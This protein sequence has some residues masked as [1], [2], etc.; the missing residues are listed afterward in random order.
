MQ[1]STLVGVSMALAAAVAAGA[2]VWS[3]LPA[4]RTVQLHISGLPD[5][6]STTVRFGLHEAEAIAPGVYE[7]TVRT[8]ARMLQVTGGLGEPCE[9]CCFSLSQDVPVA[10]NSEAITLS[11]TVPECPT[12]DY[13]TVRVA[14]GAVRIDGVAAESRRAVV[15]GAPIAA[16]LWDGDGGCGEP[17]VGCVAW[18]EVI[19]FANRLSIAEGLTPAYYHDVAHHFPYDHRGGTVHWS[20]AADGWR[21]PTE[22]E[23]VLSIGTS[24]AWEWIWGTFAEPY[25]GVTTTQEEDGPRTVRGPGRTARI[26]P[27]A[28]LGFRLVRDAPPPALPQQDARVRPPRER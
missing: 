21:L 9:R 6:G 10:F 5:W 15:V 1:K 7:G 22:A 24:E 2:V 26:A 11:A 3:L 16:A 17:A 27:S 25:A 13:A 28:D 12:A 4:P 18:L 19:R 14:P 23:W 20:R 8:G